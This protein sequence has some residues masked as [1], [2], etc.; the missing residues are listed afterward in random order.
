MPLRYSQRA[1]ALKARRTVQRRLVR[2]VIFEPQHL[3]A[4]AQRRCVQRAAGAKNCNLRHAQSRC[5]MHQA[6]VV[7]YY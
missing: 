2:E 5:N 4:L 1:D 6:R 7:S 3:R